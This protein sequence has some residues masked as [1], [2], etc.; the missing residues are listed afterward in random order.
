MLSFVPFLPLQVQ[1]V[2]VKQERVTCDCCANLLVFD[3][4]LLC[5][6]SAK[7]AHVSDAVQG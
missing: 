4:V 1:Y 2:S 5:S 7:V 6:R 3:V